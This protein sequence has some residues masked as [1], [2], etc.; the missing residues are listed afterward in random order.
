MRFI[1]SMFI[2]S[3]QISCFIYSN[4]SDHGNEQ[5]NTALKVLGDIKG[6]ANSNQGL[7][8]YFVIAAE[9]GRTIKDLCEYVK[10]NDEKR[11]K[12]A[13]HYHFSGSKNARI[14]E[15]VEKL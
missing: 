7:K 11:K 14:N 9:L 3:Q 10:I 13:E 8:E 5:G 1:C 2:F 15:K 4:R 6:I 12:T